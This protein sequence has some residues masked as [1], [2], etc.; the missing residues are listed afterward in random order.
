MRRYLKGE[1]LDYVVIINSKIYGNLGG[2]IRKRRRRSS[3]FN[4]SGADIIRIRFNS[5]SLYGVGNE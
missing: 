3:G 1:D 2:K 5:L 4:D